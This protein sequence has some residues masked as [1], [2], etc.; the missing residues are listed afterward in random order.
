[1]KGAIKFAICWLVLA[2]VLA[3]ALGRVNIPTYLRLARQ[4]ERATAT[5]VRPDCG[6]H[7]EAT[8]AYDV[9]SRRYFG[10]DVMWKLDCGALRSGD[11]ISI[12]Y[13]TTDPAISRAIEPKDGLI[14]DLIPIGLACLMVPPF[15]IAAFV[16]SWRKSKA[17]SS[18]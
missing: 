16:V 10:R 17:N 1:M 6:N 9:G 14:N 4:G 18:N 7:A 11:S 13:D 8:Y 12:Y 5:I 2:A 3:I 15:F